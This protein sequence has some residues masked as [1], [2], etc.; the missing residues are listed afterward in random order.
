MSGELKLK[1]SGIEKSF[2]GVKALDRVTFS[3]RAGTV[4]ALCGENGA[5]KSTL[6][7]IINGIY[8]PDKGEISIDG[9]PVV[10]Q[11]PESAKAHGIAMIAQ[12][13]NFVPEL[14]VEENL[15]LGRLPVKGGKI[16]WGRVRRETQEL[17][18]Q[19]GLPFQPTQQMKTLSVSEIQQLEILK[20]LSLDAQII[21]MDEPSSSISNKEVENLF[22]KIKALRA[23]GR[24]IV[25]ISH[26]MD[27]VFEIADEVTVLRDGTVVS[28]HPIEELDHDK[29]ISLMREFDS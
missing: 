11:N 23:E 4:H 1:V 12:E 19:E 25:Y 5:G 2:P 29:V 17:L 18:K 27:E 9:V 7:K 10:I 16:D 13:L 24:C 26:K 15:F 21:I 28:T 6:M 14:T 3:V 20:A 8:S 22:K